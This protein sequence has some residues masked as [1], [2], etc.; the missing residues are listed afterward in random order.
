DIMG[1]CDNQWVSDYT[2]NAL[3]SRGQHVNMPKWQEAPAADE[4]VA[5]DVISV[6]GAGQAEWQQRITR[7]TLRELPTVPVHLESKT[8][9]RDVQGHYYPYDHLPGGWLLV[10]A[11][12]FEANRARFAIDGKELDATNQH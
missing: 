3:L 6:N 1:Y 4:R 8:A 7:E 5:Y 12:D 9:T 2:F 10:P 11:G